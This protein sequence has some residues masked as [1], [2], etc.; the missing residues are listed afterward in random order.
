MGSKCPGCGHLRA[1]HVSNFCLHDGNEECRC[2]RTFT[3]TV[4]VMTERQLQALVM[5]L[6]DALGLVGFHVFDSRRSNPGFPD[7]VA[8]GRHGVLYR[9]LK[10]AR[11][12][13]S[14]MQ[15][16]WLD[17]LL[18]AGQDAAVWRPEDWPDRITR[19]LRA[20]SAVVTEKPVPTQAEL[21]KKVASRGRK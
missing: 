5:D 14:P 7:V 19:E 6:I 18:A 8:V 13:L 4:S 15:V 12:R 16:Y 21:R 20:L 17:T 9:E 3:P 10:T 11:G 1:H 2:E